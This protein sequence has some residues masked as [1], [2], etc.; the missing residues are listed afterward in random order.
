MS[1]CLPY[2]WVGILRNMILIVIKKMYNMR[3]VFY[4][5]QF[6]NQ[7]Q[8]HNLITNVWENCPVIS[9]QRIFADFSL[10]Q[11]EYLFTK[12]KKQKKLN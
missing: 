11:Q 1:G 12:Q 10:E 3:Y 5:G 8:T 6:S 9:A 7:L 4:H 2:F